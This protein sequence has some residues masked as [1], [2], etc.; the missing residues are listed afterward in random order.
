MNWNLVLSTDK[1]NWAALITGGGKWSA[2]S[3][4]MKMEK[5]KYL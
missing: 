1:N 5:V 2:D 3:Y 4:L